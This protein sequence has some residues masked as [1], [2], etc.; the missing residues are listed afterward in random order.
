MVNELTLS[1]R[2]GEIMGLLGPNGAGKSTTMRMLT[3]GIA[4]SSG[5][6]YVNGLPVTGSDTSWRRA[7]GYLP[8]QNPLYPEMYVSE[9]LRYVARLYGVARPRQ[10]ADRVAELTGL[11]KERG[12]RI[13]VLSK[14]YRQRVGLAAAL[15][16]NPTT[17]ILDEPTNGLDPNQIVEI[18]RVIRDVGRERAV[19]LSTHI[20]Q[21]VEALCDSVAIVSRGS[22]MA[23][24]PTSEVV[25]RRNARTFVV[26]FGAAVELAQ[27]RADF[28]QL[29][30]EP[31][32]KG[33]FALHGRDGEDY[34]AAL[35]EY[36]VA[37]RLPLLTL[38]ER[39]S[40]L[41]DVFRALTQG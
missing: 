26:G 13:G 17:L 8:E 23:Q 14:G 28:P 5:M 34:R 15:I 22:L 9:Y 27:L 39:E 41:E 11:T 21:E 38:Y 19:L 16:G 10:E 33:E 36:A 6:A 2:P 35:Y 24:G 31:L 3:G 25:S 1:V 32:P 12:R 20:M 7:L 29:E 37:R 30:V 18:R 40:H 4:P